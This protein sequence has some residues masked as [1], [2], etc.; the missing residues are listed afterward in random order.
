MI[1]PLLTADAGGPG[2]VSFAI[3]IALLFAIMYFLLFRP[4]QK[5][6]KQH[7]EKIEAVERGNEVVTGGG[8][9]GKVT[10]VTEDYVE[11]EIASGVRVRSVKSMLSDVRQP[12]GAAAND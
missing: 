5:R 12:G 2:F 11:V 9:I 1:L 4:Q 6:A 7:K 3:Q 8:L 10:K